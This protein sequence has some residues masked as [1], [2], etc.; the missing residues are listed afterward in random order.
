MTS[1]LLLVEPSTTMRFVLDNYVQSLGHTVVS[2]GDYHEAVEALRDQY[3]SFDNDFDA[4]ILGWPSVAVREADTLTA[5]LE[6]HDFHAMPVVV[7]S[8]DQRAETRAWVADRPNSAMLAWKSYESVDELLR[9]LIQPRQK[10]ATTQAQPGAAQRSLKFDNRDVSVLL[11]DDS[12]SIRESLSNVLTLHGY[13]I[14][15]AESLEAAQ[16]ILRRQAV[17]IAIVDFYLQNETGDEVCKAL[18]AEAPQ[19]VCAILTSAYSDPIIKLSLKAGAVDC[20]FK[21]EAGELLLARIDA[22]ARV[23]RQ[24]KALH[25]E[26]ERLDRLVDTLAG[27]TLLID[28]ADQLTYVSEHAAE[29]LGFEDRRAINGQNLSV[30]LDTE[31]LRISGTGRHTAYWVN[32]HQVPVEVV[33]RLVAI[34]N[35]TE[36]MINFRMAANTSASSQVSAGSA[37]QNGALPATEIQTASV[38]SAVAREPETSDRANLPDESRSATATDNTSI[39]NRTASNALSATERKTIGAGEGQEYSQPVLGNAYSTEAADRFLHQLIDYLS[40]PDAAKEP[41]SLLMLGVMFRFHD[42]TLMPCS[43][44]AELDVAT[45]DSLMSIYRRENHVAQ[46]AGHRY[47]FLLRHTD[48][49]Q[50]YLL[51]RKIMQ[52]CNETELPDSLIGQGDLCVNGCLLGLANHTS[53]PAQDLLSQ[54]LGGLRAVDVRGIN[55]A[56]LLDLKRMLPV[57]PANQ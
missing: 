24:R 25:T 26:Q 32:A 10:P 28:E 11:I 41:V 54:A 52:L 7:M 15:A 33:Y 47:G 23:V 5:L 50:S 44:N 57:Y 39:N 40:V 35:T 34:A 30:L 18:L 8:T 45:H 21:N 48:A 2:V 46:L 3:Q 17:D 56:L 1:R 38:E 53:T 19:L 49:P 43:N 22:L 4:I 14:T 27:A 29:L 6:Q 51:T 12:P 31:K 55:Q 13:T 9:S 42:G 20:F 36:R 37:Q 16:S